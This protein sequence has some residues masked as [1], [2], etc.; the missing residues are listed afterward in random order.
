MSNEST[1]DIVGITKMPIFSSTKW[2]RRANE[3]YPCQTLDVRICVQIGQSGASPSW[4]G[5]CHGQTT[6]SFVEVGELRVVRLRSRDLGVLG[7]TCGVTCCIGC[8]GVT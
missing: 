6:V 2:R 3:S 4:V 8:F 7:V 1:K 5:I